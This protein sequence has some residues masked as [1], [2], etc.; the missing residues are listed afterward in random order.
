MWFAASVIGTT[1]RSSRV[2]LKGPLV[3]MDEMKQAHTNAAGQIDISLVRHCLQKGN[4]KLALQCCYEL[5]AED[6]QHILALSLAA[7]AP[8]SL[9]WLDVALDFIDRAMAV[10]HTSQL[11]IVSWGV[12]CS[13]KRSQ[14]ML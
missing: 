13:C 14:S 1:A 2:S 11:F 9:G 7:V 5:L 3:L 6:P 10:R 4:A 12:Y 8:R